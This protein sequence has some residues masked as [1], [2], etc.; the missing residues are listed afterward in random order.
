M[1]K[2]LNGPTVY[3]TKCPLC[4]TEFEYNY[5]DTEEKGMFLEDDYGYIRVVTCPTCQTPLT[6]DD[7]RINPLTTEN[8]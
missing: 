3:R 7:N 6:H 2:I 5:S 8:L 1:K 4:N